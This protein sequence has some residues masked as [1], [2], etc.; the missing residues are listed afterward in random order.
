MLLLLRGSIRK[1]FLCRC[2]LVFSDD[3]EGLWR[4]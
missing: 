4:S 1:I 3:S 2:K